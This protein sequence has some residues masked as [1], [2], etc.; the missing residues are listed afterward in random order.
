M[1]NVERSRL[2]RR[3]NRFCRNKV[4]DAIYTHFADSWVFVHE[5]QTPTEFVEFSVTSPVPQANGGKQPEIRPE[6]QP[7][8][9]P[10]LQP[11]PQ[12]IDELIDELFGSASPQPCEEEPHFECLDSLDY[13]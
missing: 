3:R 11:E 6:P 10:S 5:L 13:I 9:Q 1:K 7:E 8:P 2:H 4:M 12:C